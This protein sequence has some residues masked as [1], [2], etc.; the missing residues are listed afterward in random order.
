MIRKAE[1]NARD[2]YEQ[3][4]C[5][6]VLDPFTPRLI[7]RCEEIHK[8]NYES[9]CDFLD[10]QRERNTYLNATS[11]RQRDLEKEV[12]LAANL[13]YADTLLRNN[14]V[15]YEDGCIKNIRELRKIYKKFK[16]E[17]DRVK[18]RSGRYDTSKNGKTIRR[19]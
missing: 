11:E 7:E 15:T 14:N 17:S 9:L 19:I 13:R 4:S 8:G 12:Q 10:T 1:I 2:L 16:S 6:F 18:P 5:R 3:M